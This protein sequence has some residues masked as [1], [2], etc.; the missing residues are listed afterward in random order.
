MCACGMY[1][2]VWVGEHGCVYA[3]NKDR[4]SEWVSE[5]VSEGGSDCVSE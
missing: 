4:V 2:R 5:G 1:I 3:G